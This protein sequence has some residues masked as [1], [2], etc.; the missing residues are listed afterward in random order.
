M[1][2]MHYGT[3]MI[4]MH[5][6]WFCSYRIREILEEGGCKAPTACIKTVF[7]CFSFAYLVV[8]PALLLP[9][10][11][12]VT[13]GEQGTILLSS[14]ALIVRASLWKFITAHAEDEDKECERA[15]ML[16]YGI[17]ACVIWASSERFFFC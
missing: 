6:K 7:F 15:H 10:F 13:I 17:V 1:F 4:T 11:L 2:S 14:G 3:T 12:F 16:N 9:S 5:V 8:A